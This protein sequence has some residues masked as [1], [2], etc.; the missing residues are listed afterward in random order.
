MYPIYVATSQFHQVVMI[1][2]NGSQKRLVVVMSDAIVSTITVFFI[3][4]CRKKEAFFWKFCVKARNCLYY[5]GYQLNAAIK[6]DKMNLKPTK[7]W[8]T[9]SSTRC[10]N[11]LH[12]WKSARRPSVILT[13]DSQSTGMAG[14]LHNWKSSYKS[15]SCL[16]RLSIKVSSFLGKN[17]YLTLSLEKTSSSSS[18][19]HFSKQQKWIWNSLKHYSNPGQTSLHRLCG[20]W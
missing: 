20:L 5:N 18:S 6:I 13:L 12:I 10:G 16:I 17:H 4:S 1:F 14:R 7:V 2:T 3:S 19:S 11:Y 8:V 15:K 9:K